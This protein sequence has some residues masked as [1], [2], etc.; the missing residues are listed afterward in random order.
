MASPVFGFTV[1]TGPGDPTLTL[2]ASVEG[3]A[4][5]RCPCLRGDYR[6]VQPP[7]SGPIA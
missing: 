3:K 6:G 2:P 4:N 5:P 1:V 7:G